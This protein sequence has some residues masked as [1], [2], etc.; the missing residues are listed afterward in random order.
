MVLELLDMNCAGAHGLSSG[1]FNALNGD[2]FW[3]GLISG[4]AYLVAR[5]KW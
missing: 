1:V 4:A 5:H 3:N 2:N